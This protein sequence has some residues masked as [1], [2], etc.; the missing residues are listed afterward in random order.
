MVHIGV[1]PLYNK[2]TLFL[3]LVSLMY[4]ICDC[5]TI[6]PLLLFFLC[7]S[8]FIYFQIGKITFFVHYHDHGL[9]DLQ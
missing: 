7:K 9:V 3:P 1:A 8:V 6:L 4:I 5:N 2:E